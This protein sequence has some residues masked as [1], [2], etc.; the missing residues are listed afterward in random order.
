MP[1]TAAYFNTELPQ[2]LASSDLGSSDIFQFDID[3]AGVWSVNLGESTVTEGASDNADCVITTDK[4]TWEQ[5]LDDP[6][7]AM[8][9]FMAQ[10]LKVS[11]INKAL[12]LQ[13]ILA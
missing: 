6:S 8:R 2:K 5:V 3:G 11:N 4:A 12:F 9:L 13:K 1:D 7:A 10:K